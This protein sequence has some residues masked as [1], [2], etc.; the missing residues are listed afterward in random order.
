MVLSLP[1]GQCR[2]LI[3]HM[4]LPYPLWSDSDWKVFD[5]Y[6]TGHVLFA[7]KQAWMVIDAD[8][9]LRWTWRSGEAGKSRQVP[10]PLDVLEEARS[11]LR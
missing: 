7:P 9:I 10:M 6:G 5:D 1:I 11:A 3:E 4:G 2:A 8:G